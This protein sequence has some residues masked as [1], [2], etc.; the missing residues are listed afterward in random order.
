MREITKLHEEIIRGNLEVLAKHFA[1]NPTKGEIVLIIERF[2]ISDFSFQLSDKKILTE[3]IGELEKEGFDNKN[4]LKKAAKEFGLS[5]S[6][7]YR[8]VKVKSEK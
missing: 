8:R 6:E 5:K 3:R 7:A 2:Q 4:A 1:E